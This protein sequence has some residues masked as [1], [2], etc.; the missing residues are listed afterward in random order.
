[1]MLVQSGVATIVTARPDV[2][3][4]DVIRSLNTVIYDNIH[5]RLEAERH[6][7]LSLLRYRSNGTFVVAG[8]HMD[9]VVW[10]AETKTI[11]LLGT[12]G[13]FLAITQDIDQVNQETTWQLHKDDLLVLLTDGV[14]EAEDRGGHPFEYKRVTD[15]VEAHAGEPV[16]AIRDA[17]FAGLTK[18][19]PTLADDATI[20][21]LRYVGD[22]S[23]S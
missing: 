23:A 11:E 15:L 18:H 17:L 5:D 20:L 12:P 10:R 22:A 21:V 14:T 7:T 9:G 19:S 6:M 3:P 8:A 1:M 13:T 16:A 2:G 4:K